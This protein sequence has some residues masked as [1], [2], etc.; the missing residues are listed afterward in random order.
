MWNWRFDAPPTEAPRD[1]ECHVWVVPIR[2]SARPDD[3]ADQVERAEAERYRHDGARATYVTSRLAQRAV[4]A[5]YLGV[6]PAQV[7]IDRTCE[8][9]GD[10]RHGRPRL[11]STRLDQESL[12]Y[13]VSHSGD[14]CLIAVATA[15]VGVDIERLGALEDVSSISARTLTGLE[16][17]A[18]AAV[19]PDAQEAWFYRSWARK[20]A[21]VKATGEGL[22]M[23]MSSV[24]VR[25]ATIRASGLRLW[26][27]DL[28]APAGYAAALA[29][30]VRINR[31]SVIGD[32]AIQSR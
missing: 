24:D 12:E 1:G 10:P 13:S 18:F 4:L 26:L 7:E 32:G 16:R 11:R 28:K 21:T 8:A 5:R 19:A 6:D 17:A 31:L 27:R 14:W 22:R 20:E 30:G 23:E 25:G 2:P 3:L 15:A 9:C 29:T